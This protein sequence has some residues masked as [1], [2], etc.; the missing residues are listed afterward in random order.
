MPRCVDSRGHHDQSGLSGL[1]GCEKV[2]ALKLDK[3]NRCLIHGG[4]LVP[5]K[6]KANHFVTPHGGVALTAK[7][8]FIRSFTVEEDMTGLWKDLSLST[9]VTA[10]WVQIMPKIRAL[11][12]S[13]YGETSKHDNSYLRVN[14]FVL[15]K[16]FAIASQFG[17]IPIM[18]CGD[19]QA[20]PDE[21]SAIVAAKRF[22][23]WCDPLCATD[24]LGN[25]TRPIT[26]SR[27]AQFCNPSE[28]YFSSIDA[29]LF[30]H[31]ASLALV[32]IEM[33][34][35]QAKQHAPI[36][37]KFSWPKI[38]V[39]GTV[40][41]I[42][43]PLDL[44]K[45]PRKHNGE[46]DLCEMSR[47]AEILWHEKFQSKCCTGDDDY[48]WEQL[49]A[50]ALES[51]TSCGAKFKPGLA[52][53][54]EKPSFKLS[55]PCPGQSLSGAVTKSIAELENFHKQIVE[56]TLRLSRCATNRNDI[57]LTNC[58]FLKVRKKAF[59]YKLEFHDPD[60][61]ISI[62]K[63]K[64]L[65]KQ[66][67]SLINKKRDTAKRERIKN[68]KQKMIHG[69][70]TKTVHSFVYKWIKGKT[71]VEVPNLIIDSCGNI[72][73]N[74]NEAIKEF[75]LQWI[76]FSHL[77]CFIKSLLHFLSSFGPTLMKSDPKQ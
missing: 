36:V 54:A 10:A 70:T 8:G 47:Q 27:N 38:M 2:V 71:Q 56:P 61:F 19:F 16:V 72:L 32:S 24:S 18:L 33:D 20:E 46:L 4:L 77:T 25:P 64:D 31:V 34:Y 15:E 17:E 52:V 44:E 12:F 14:N 58:L 45:L 66:V 59:P 35:S 30:N 21:Y 22:G 11:I 74:P 5:K 68:W 1:R 13:F 50:F 42:P 60:G 48:D 43:A 75:N 28:Y 67:M 65:Q 69:T 41:N 62:E 73:Y 3:S 63:L 9:R 55:K 49:N 40:L 76:R 26:F 29:I 7:K 6:T 53:R 37:A 51:L 57:R 39:E 23:K